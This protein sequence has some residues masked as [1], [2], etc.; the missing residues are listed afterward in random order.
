MN[1]LPLNAS[2]SQFRRARFGAMIQISM[3]GSMRLA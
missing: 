3:D 1:R 2:E